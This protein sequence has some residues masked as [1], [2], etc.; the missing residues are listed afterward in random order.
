MIK[1]AWDFRVGVA[2]H[3]TTRE[4]LQLHDVDLPCIILNSKFFKQNCNFLT[5]WSTQAVQLN[6]VLSFRGQWLLRSCTCRWPIHSPHNTSQ[7]LW[8]PY[9][10]YHILRRQTW[11]LCW[12]TKGIGWCYG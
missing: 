6:W 5:I 11:F 8:C 1:H 10:R 3:K 7:F 9:C 12:G 2:I 4:L